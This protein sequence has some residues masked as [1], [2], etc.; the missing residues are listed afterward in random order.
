MAAP[1]SGL[2]IEENT[3]SFDADG[4]ADMAV[5]PRKSLKILDRGGIDYRS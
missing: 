2:D 4:A 1:L 3:V 5:F